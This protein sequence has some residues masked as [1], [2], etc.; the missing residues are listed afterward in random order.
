ML[1]AT[2][3]IE[4]R[5]LVLSVPIVSPLTGL[6][7]PRQVLPAS[8]KV[9]RGYAAARDPRIANQDVVICFRC[10]ARE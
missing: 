2:P 7:R 5:I 8:I 1:N 3:V 6:E 9:Y 10:I 4:E